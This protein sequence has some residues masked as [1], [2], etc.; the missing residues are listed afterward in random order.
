MKKIN[1]IIFSLLF[2]GCSQTNYVNE[3]ELRKMINDETNGLKKTITSNEIK[4]IATYKPADLVALNE[5]KTLNEKKDKKI[6]DSILYKYSGNYFFTLSFSID[7]KSVITEVAP[8]IREEVLNKFNYGL[9]STIFITYNSVTGDHEDTLQLSNYMYVS[10]FGAANSD[11]VIISFNKE[12]VQ[13]QKLFTINIIDL[14]AIGVT[15]K[16][17]F[18]TDDIEKVPKINFNN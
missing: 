17:V 9:K 8:S 5:I 16:I 11:D 6:I 10:M 15:E 1:N 13:K 7:N 2:W 3:T 12:Q 4:V 14:S 18:N